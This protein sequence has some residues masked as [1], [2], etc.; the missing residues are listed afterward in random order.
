MS[1]PAYFPQSSSSSTLLL[2]L[3]RGRAPLLLPGELAHHGLRAADDLGPALR[4]VLDRLDV[5]RL[6]VVAAVEQQVVARQTR[7]GGGSRE[8]QRRERDRGQTGEYAN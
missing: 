7:V 1:L 6:A 3:H 8:T 4:P 5:A 2:D